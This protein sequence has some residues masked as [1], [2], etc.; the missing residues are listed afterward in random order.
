MV[1]CKSSSNSYNYY[2]SIHENNISPYVYIYI[3]TKL[4]VIKYAFQKS[5]INGFTIREG[6][7]RLGTSYVMGF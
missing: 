7:S 6:R 4:K 3:Y 5:G 1:A 2:T